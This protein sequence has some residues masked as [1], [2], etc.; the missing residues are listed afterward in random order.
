MRRA[1]LAKSS[2]NSGLW[3]CD[4][5]TLSSTGSGITEDPKGLLPAELPPL[6]FKKYNGDCRVHL[7][8]K[9][10]LVASAS[11]GLISRLA[12]VVIEAGVVAHMT[13]IIRDFKSSE[14]MEKENVFASMLVMV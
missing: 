2:W 11:D 4:S 9:L 8:R 5:G 3:S 12:C 13:M 10:L 6:K 7:Q 14:N 1:R